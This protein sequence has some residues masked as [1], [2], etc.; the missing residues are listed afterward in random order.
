MK[1][2]VS[3]ALM[4]SV[5]ASAVAAGA[6]TRDYWVQFTSKLPI[7]STVRVRTNDGKR[8][9]AVLAIVDDAG[10]TI[11]PKT[12]RPEAPRHIPFEQLAQIEIKQDGMSAGKAAAIGA[13]V[14][15]GVFL[16]IMAVAMALFND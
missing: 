1:Q 15:G 6:Q 5:L 12:R 2:I 16:A 14:G 10:I 4:L 7:G 11:A 13:A 9:T 3:C 8:I